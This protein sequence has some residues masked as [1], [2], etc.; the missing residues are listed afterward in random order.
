MQRCVSFVLME[1]RKFGQ[2]V[3]DRREALGLSQ[4]ALARSMQEF[5]FENWHQTTVSR[6]EAGERKVKAVTE[7]KALEQILKIPMGA[8]NEAHRTVQQALHGPYGEEAWKLGAYHWAERYANV[9]DA[10]NRAQVAI[11]ELDEAIYQL[12]FMGRYFP[13]VEDSDEG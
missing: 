5:G 3:K 10:F 2:L 4:N 12:Q 1:Q 9:K 11:A 7:L 6:V 8:E 13:P